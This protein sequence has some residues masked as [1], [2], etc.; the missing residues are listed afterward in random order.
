MKFII[1]LFA[2]LSIAKLSNAQSNWTELNTGFSFILTNI[3]FPGNQDSIG[4]AVGMSSTYNGNG[5]ILKTT[6]AGTT[7]NQI[8]TTTIPGLEAMYFTS[9]DTGFIGGWQN[10]FAKTTNGGL[11]WTPSTVNSSIWYIT[12]IAFYD[13][14]NGIVTAAG[15]VAYVTNNGGQTWTA[16]TGL[17]VNAQDISYASANVVYIVGG[18]EKI[19]RS[20]NGGLSWTTIQTGMFQMMFLG[21]DF[22]DLNHGIVGG[23]DGKVLRTSNGGQ[24]WQTSYVPGNP[25]LRAAYMQDSLNAIIAG[26]P[27]GIYITNDGGATWASD[28]MGGFSFAI[29]DADFSANGTGFICGSQG[30]IWK[31]AAPI[32][33]DF[34]AANTFSCT[35]DSFF[36]SDQ[37]T[38]AIDIWLW[39][40]PGGNP[41]FHNGQTP[42]GIYYGAPGS[43]DV[44]L[45]II[46]GSQ[47][48][49]ILMNSLI[50]IEVQHNFQ[51]T[52]T[53]FPGS[54]VWDFSTL[55]IPGYSY[56]WLVSPTGTI[57][58]QGN[59]SIQIVVP[60]V[61]VYSVIVVTESANGCRDT[62][63]QRLFTAFASVDELDNS[64]K[65]Y[66]NPTSGIM[67]IS[68]SK[69]K[70]MNY[71]IMNMTGQL[72][73]AGLCTETVDFSDL[74]SGLYILELQDVSGLYRQRVM[75]Q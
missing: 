19:A 54:F 58:N 32:V 68:I 46:S 20:T 43:Y 3:S 70:E 11:T 41:S 30:R 71:S 69:Q 12:N 17:A 7:W 9:I 1:T 34:S 5:I 40:F 35:P 16:A 23:E 72:V 44:Q 63:D 38:G 50:E 61:G 53:T 4:Y 27:E 66:P 24:T 56:L 28:Y 18:D 67:N 26:T 51:I 45:T 10:Y 73:K 75:K 49:T 13:G 42:P 21:V 25:L 8:N 2:L 55:S 47:S 36:F 29:Y 65:I 6:D 57:I 37:S 60:T 15:G 52:G 39:D 33:A 31:K 74:E 62:S 59:S 48:D 64:I 22:Y 14:Q